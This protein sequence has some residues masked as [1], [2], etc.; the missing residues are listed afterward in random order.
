MVLHG[1]SFGNFTK[2]YET[3]LKNNA[4]RTVLGS[5]VLADDLIQILNKDEFKI[6]YFLAAETIINEGY[7]AIERTSAILSK[8]AL[9]SKVN[10]KHQSGSN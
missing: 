5:A 10:S 6:P 9:E 3:S 7:I 8:I 2:I 1:P 4:T